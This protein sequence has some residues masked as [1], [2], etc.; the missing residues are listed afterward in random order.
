M[1]LLLIAGFIHWI[2]RLAVAEGIA[3]GIVFLINVLFGISISYVIA[4]SV[5]GAL[6]ILGLVYPTLVVIGSWQTLK[7]TVD[8]FDANA[9]DDL[10]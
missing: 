4:A 10:L 8:K 9:W 3:L 5:V 1:I 6:M 2:I 7:K